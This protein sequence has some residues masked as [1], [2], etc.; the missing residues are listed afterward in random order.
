MRRIFAVL[1]ASSCIVVFSGCNFLNP[2]AQ[3]QSFK[4]KVAEKLSLNLSGAMVVEEWDTHGGFH[5]DGEAFLKMTVADG[6]ENT[7]GAG[8]RAFPLTEESEVYR[9]YYEWGG[10]FENPD[11]PNEK[12]IPEIENGFWWYEAE[13]AGLNFNFAALDMDTDTLYYYEF[14]S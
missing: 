5:G 4:E 13:G 9:Y 11:K 10:M 2:F 14:D 1:A 3:K 8:W 6:F 7:L 12:I